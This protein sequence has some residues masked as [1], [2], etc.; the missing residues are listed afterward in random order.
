MGNINIATRV[1]FDLHAL[2]Q[3]ECEIKGMTVSDF[4]RE[5][6]EEKCKYNSTPAS[7]V[8]STNIKLPLDTFSLVNKSAI[9]NVGGLKIYVHAGK[10]LCFYIKSGRGINK[11]CFEYQRFSKQVWDYAL[12]TM[13]NEINYFILL[14]LAELMEI[15]LEKPESWDTQEKIEYAYDYY[16]EQLQGFRHT[17]NADLNLHSKYLGAV[18]MKH[19]HGGAT[20]LRV[21]Y[22]DSKSLD[23]IVQE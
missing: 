16:Y 6:L 13:P 15:D 20:K 11:H 22:L 7:H 5:A 12:K 2:I 1:S 17:I 3:R 18:E 21:V 23:N 4:L 10:R 14:N 8:T 19:T 9:S